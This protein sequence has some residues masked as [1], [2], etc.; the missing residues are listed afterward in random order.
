MGGKHTRG[1]SLS[2]LWKQ[3]Q[4]VTYQVHIIPSAPE[5]PLSRECS[6]AANKSLPLS[7]ANTDALTN[8]SEYPQNRRGIIEILILMILVIILKSEPYLLTD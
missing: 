7:V 4:G 8:N 3:S 1:I 5:K 2:L 6:Q